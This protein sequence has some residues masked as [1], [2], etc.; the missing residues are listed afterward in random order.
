MSC[1]IKKLGLEYQDE[2]AI[3]PS[4]SFRCSILQNYTAPPPKQTDTTV[5]Q[6]E[7]ASN[8]FILLGIQH[9]FLQGQKSAA[10]KSLI[11]LPTQTPCHPPSQNDT[12][13]NRPGLKFHSYIYI[14]QSRSC[15]VQSCRPQMATHYTFTTD[16]INLLSNFISY[17]KLQRR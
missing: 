12:S 14:I 10:P 7:A 3:R 15:R 2:G 16:K 13:E 5:D 6:I 8:T 9:P 1:S 11:F 4:V 17:Y